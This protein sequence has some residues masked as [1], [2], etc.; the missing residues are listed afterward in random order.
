[1]SSA[2]PTARPW[3]NVCFQ[4]YGPR[5]EK[6]AHTG[7]GQRPPAE[8]HESE[9]NAEFIVRAVNAHDG[10]LA[11]LKNLEQAAVAMLNCTDDSERGYLREEAEKSRA[12]IAEAEAGAQS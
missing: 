6:I 9:A 5:N 10:M 12:T 1:M 11:A 3:R 4:V 8:S 7:M 2:Q